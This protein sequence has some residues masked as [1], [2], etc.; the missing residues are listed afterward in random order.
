MRVLITGASRGL[1]AA[2]AF[3]FVR[4]FPGARLALLA[5]SLD[6]PV[7]DQLQGDLRRIARDAEAL[8][9]EVAVPMALD[10]RAP[11]EVISETVHAALDALRDDAADLRRLDVLVNNASALDTTRR[12]TPKRTQL[13]L[14]VNARGTLAVSLACAPALQAADGAVVTLSPP[15]NLQQLQWLGQHPHYTVSKYAM[16]LSTLAMAGNGLRANCVWPRYTAATAATKRLEREGVLA[17]AYSCG[18][19]AEEVAEAIVTLSQQSRVGECLFDDEVCTLPPAPLGAPL[20]AFV[21]TSE[22]TASP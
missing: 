21:L 5:R 14:D 7:S 15:V 12:P 18:R 9:A 11:C 22:G 1:G 19:P 6:A 17:N 4:R 3:R 10:L 8:G 13:V 16:T 2:T 20:D